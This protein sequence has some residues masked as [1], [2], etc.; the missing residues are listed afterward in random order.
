MDNRPLAQEPKG[1]A[2]M[3]FP[4]NQMSLQD[5]Q[6]HQ[7][8]TLKVLCKE[9]VQQPNNQITFT[10][11]GVPLNPFTVTLIP[12]SFTAIVDQDKVFNT[13]QL[14]VT[15][16]DASGSATSIITYREDAVVCPLD[17]TQWPGQVVVQKHDV[18]FRIIGEPVAVGQQITINFVIN[19]CLIVAKEVLLEV[20]GAIQF[21]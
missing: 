8:K 9:R 14:Q 20:N 10:V 21:C 2:Q 18:E 6:D 11:P 5:F 15:A 19:Y 12:L 1:G 3:G 4:S 13:W 16:A 7:L 17:L